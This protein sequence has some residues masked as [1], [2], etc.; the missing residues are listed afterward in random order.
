M[1]L[2]TALYVHPTEGHDANDGAI[3]QV[4]P[5]AHV[6]PA[7]FACAVLRNFPFFAAASYY[8]AVRGSG[9]GQIDHVLFPRRHIQRNSSGVDIEY[10]TTINLGDTGDSSASDLFDATSGSVS[11]AVSNGNLESNIKSAASASR[12]NLL[13]H[14]NLLKSP[15]QTHFACSVQ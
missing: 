3:S 7:P 10:T 2:L 14:L 15:N 11:S 1:P 6:H 13:C 4:H 8:S 9:H 5:P 12:Y